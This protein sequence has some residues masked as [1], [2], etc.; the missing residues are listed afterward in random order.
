MSFDFQIA[1]SMPLQNGRGQDVSTTP[2]AD[3]TP[4]AG[5]SSGQDTQRA[6]AAQQN[7]GITDTGPANLDTANDWGLWPQKLVEVQGQFEGVR[8]IENGAGVTGNVLI[9]TAI[10]NVF[11]VNMSGD[12]M[13][14]VDGLPAVPSDQGGDR[15]RSGALNL[16]FKPNGHQ[17]RFANRILW[18]QGEFSHE[19]D[20]DGYL[21][22]CIQPLFGPGLPGIFL[23]FVC[24]QNHK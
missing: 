17:V 23:G 10:A 2:R 3:P 16:V 21:V 11:Y 14:Y 19:T 6:A 15:P 13:V 4:A 20:N 22:V 24:G 12:V 8:P 5:S 9:R 7:G 1:Q 18:D